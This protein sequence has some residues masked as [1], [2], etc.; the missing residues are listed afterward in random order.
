M[1]VRILH[2]PRCRK[3]R[4]ALR[5]RIVEPEIVLDPENPPAKEKLRELLARAGL[6]ARAVARAKEAK[7]AGLDPEALSE[8]E[9]LDLPVRGPRLLERP[10]VATVKGV[11]LA[12]PPERVPEVP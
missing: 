11:V 3:S 1:R 8:E 10:I 6:S 12:R 2:N 4:E 9:A 5:K 7:A